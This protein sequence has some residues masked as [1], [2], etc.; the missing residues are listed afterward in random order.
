M[1]TTRRSFVGMAGALVALLTTP[2]H[3]AKGQTVTS[4]PPATPTP[5][6]AAKESGLARLA[7]ERYGKYLGEEELKMLDE[8]MASLE[9]RS[10]RLRGISLKNWE[11]PATDF[12]VRRT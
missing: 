11:E 12:Q 6:P 1:F 3:R 4:A 10:G 9:R 7:R 8:E 5:A 2:F